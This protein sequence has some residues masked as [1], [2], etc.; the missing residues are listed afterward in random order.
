MTQEHSF[1]VSRDQQ[2]ADQAYEREFKAEI[3]EKQK[4]I[5]L[6]EKGASVDAAPMLGEKIGGR[7][8]VIPAAP[9]GRK[10]VVPSDS[11]FDG[12]KPITIKGKPLAE[13]FRQPTREATVPVSIAP[14]PGVGTGNQ[15]APMVDAGGGGVRP[16]TRTAVGASPSPDRGSNVRMLMEPDGPEKAVDDAVRRMKRRWTKSLQHC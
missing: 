9:A 15:P 7:E 1:N 3:I 16:P 8:R 12:R 4:L 11:E 13:A 6:M 10:L 2:I 14:E 5:D